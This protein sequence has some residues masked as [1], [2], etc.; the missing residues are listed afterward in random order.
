[1]TLGTLNRTNF[2]SRREEKWQPPAFNRVNGVISRFAAGAR[3]FLDL[4]AGTIWND[5]SVILPRC[6]GTVVDVG[7]GAQPYR[8]LLNKSNVNY[9]GIDRCDAKEH[10]KYEIPDTIYYD[11]DRWPIA[12]AQ[13]D[14]VLCTE[15]LEHVLDYEGFL[16]ETVRCLKPGG[17]LVM[18]VPFAAR[19]HYIP[20]DYFRYTPS[21]LNALL[22][23]A[24]LSDVR[25]YPRGNAVTVAAYKVLALMSPLLAKKTGILFITLLLRLGGLLCAPLIL[26]LGAIAKITYLFDGGMTV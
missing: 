16:A 14:V 21:A 22:T 7:C 13:A 23:K 19:W 1:M 24:G 15:T 5:L 10:F 11:T 18:T 26:V 9:I 25:V 4:Q 12:D 2:V 3:R 8:E 20:Y 6:H 17:T